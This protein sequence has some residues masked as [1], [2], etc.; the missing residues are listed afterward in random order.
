MQRFIALEHPVWHISVCLLSLS[1]VRNS[2]FLFPPIPSPSIEK[3]R[4]P[5]V[6]R[7]GDGDWE[8]II[9][10]RILY[11][12]GNPYPHMHHWLQNKLLYYSIKYMLYHISTYTKANGTEVFVWQYTQISFLPPPTKKI[13]KLPGDT[14]SSSALWSGW[15]LSHYKKC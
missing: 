3:D 8:E 10:P 6:D 12:L 15:V 1:Y 7:W 4:V 13:L 11:H 14:L 9:L 2:S 5:W